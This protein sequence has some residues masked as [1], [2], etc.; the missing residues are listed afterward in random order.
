MAEQQHEYLK[1]AVSGVAVLTED[2]QCRQQCLAREDFEYWER[3][4]KNG[5]KRELK[6]SQKLKEKQ[7]QQTIAEIAEKQ[8]KTAA[9]RS[10]NCQTKSLAYCL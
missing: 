7:Y 1:E 8:Q 5:H 2:E 10:R 9:K 6:K 4:Q 3:I